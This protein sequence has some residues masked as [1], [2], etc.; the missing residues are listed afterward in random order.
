MINSK[1]HVDRNKYI[2][3]VLQVENEWE[4]EKQFVIEQLQTALAADALPSSNA[5]ATE[6][7]TPAEVNAHFSTI[8]YNKGT[9]LLRI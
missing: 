8:S 4:L 5:M 9:H 1:S 7:N 2:A 3:R 6:V